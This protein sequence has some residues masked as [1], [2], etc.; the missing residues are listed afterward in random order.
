MSQEE[1]AGFESCSPVITAAG[2]A[3]EAA[4]EVLKDAGADPWLRQKLIKAALEAALASI[5]VID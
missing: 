5:V 3:L 1:K 2:A 4:S